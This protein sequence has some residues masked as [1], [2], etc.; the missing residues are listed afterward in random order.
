MSNVNQPRRP[1]GSPAGGEFTLG[2]GSESGLSLVV[3]D[4]EGIAAAFADAQTTRTAE[5]EPDDADRAELGQVT[6]KWGDRT[7][8]GE[9]QEVE[10]VA[11]GIAIVST[12]GHG[13]V[14]LSAARNR[15]VPAP[16]RRAAG[17]YEEDCEFH[18]VARTFPEVQALRG[19]NMTPEEMF[20]D[21]DDG[22]KRWFGR[23]WAEV[24]GSPVPQETLD[25]EA[26]DAAEA[27]AHT[28]ARLARPLA[29]VT[30]V[31]E[32]N[33]EGLAPRLRA[34]VDKDLDRRWRDSDGTVK[35]LRQTLAE[36]GVTGREA[37]FDGQ[38]WEYAITQKEREGDP[39]SVYP[40]SKA[41]FDALS[42]Q[43]PD[44]TTPRESRRSKI[45]EAK[46][47]IQR[48]EAELRSMRGFRMSGYDFKRERALN[49]TVETWKTAL[50]AAEAEIVE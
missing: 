34:A 35:S 14:K 16:L 30:K 41:T 21:G 46:S 15:E 3:L 4:H 24:T 9:A 37:S 12:A 6:L 49:S 38:K 44:V 25:R 40:V 13:G 26:A 48:A 10:H 18:I 20:A 19:G 1:A 42:D 2:S 11:P 32:V 29:A 8:W 22:V 50:A 23:A 5:L 39:S 31:A 45:R 36:D 47:K 43:V 33:L 27:A 17:W 28:A 7:P